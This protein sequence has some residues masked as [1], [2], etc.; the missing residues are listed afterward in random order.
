[1]R[2]HITILIT[3]VGSGVAQ[4][5]IKALRLANEQHKRNYRLVGTDMRAMAAGLY[6]VDKGFIVPS[7]TAADY[8]ERITDICNTE[9]VDALIP[10]SE[11]EV[12]KLAENRDK[13]E[14]ATSAK[15]LV[16]PARTVRI[17]YDKWQTYQFLREKG[18]QFPKTAKPADVSALLIETGFPVI[19]KPR[20]GSGSVG[21]YEI[22]HQGELE[23]L[24]PKLDDDY[25]IQEVLVPEDS[26]HTTGIVFDSRNEV[27]D[28]I[29]MWRKIKKG[30]SYVAKV[31]DDK[32]ILTTMEL[33][34]CRL[35]VRGA[36]NLQS[37][38]T[39]RGPVVF[40]INTRFSG[41]TA[42]RAVAGLNEPDISIRNLLFGERP[43]RVEKKPIV[44][45]RHLMEVYLEGTVL[46]DTERIGVTK[47]EATVYS[48]F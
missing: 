13:V 10:G 7:S 20:T 31:I 40:E 21:I 16:S 5:I 41:T 15:V 26:E 6:R 34:A 30:A 3:G 32:Q 2:E 35:E 8:L 29:T 12:M 1:M 22:R 23:R 44:M 25:I 17:G 27:I 14:T 4:S 37:R 24:M 33:I 43:G 46:E 47:G 9:D 38:L 19:A 36:I 42:A 39:D 48:Y 45:L 18:F 11:L 28:S